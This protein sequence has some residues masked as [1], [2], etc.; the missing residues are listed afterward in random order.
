M[1]FRR[2]ALD[3]QLSMQQTTEYV[4]SLHTESFPPASISDE[5]VARIGISAAHQLER[6]GRFALAE[7]RECVEPGGDEWAIFSF[8]MTFIRCPIPGME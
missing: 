2:L 8:L 4:H 1:M 5:L 6:L 7:V 3:C